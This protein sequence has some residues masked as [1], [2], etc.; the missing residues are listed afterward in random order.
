[1]PRWQLLRLQGE[2]HRMHRLRLGRRLLRVFERLHQNELPVLPKQKV[3]R[4]H[5]LLQQRLL[6]RRV[7]GRQLLRLEGKKHRMHGL[8]LGRRLFHVFKWV[9]QIKL[10]VLPKQK[11]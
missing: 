3:R 1:M 2:K 6:E 5:V 10:P 11:V 8:R 4:R 7:S 9:H